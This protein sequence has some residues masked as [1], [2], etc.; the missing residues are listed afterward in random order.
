MSEVTRVAS[1]ERT[2]GGYRVWIKDEPSLVAEGSDFEAADKALW[3]V[4][5][6]ASGD[7]ENL[8][9]YSPPPPPDAGT[10]SGVPH[11]WELA[12]EPRAFIS[13]ADALFEGG[14]CVRCLMPR[15]PRSGVTLGL[16][17][18]LDGIDVTRAEMPRRRL[19]AGPSLSVY[20]NQFLA[21]LSPA[22]RESFTWR[23]VDVPRAGE[24]EFYEM[25]PGV[26]ASY[27]IRKGRAAS[28]RICEECGWKW[29]L[30]RYVPGLPFLSISVKDL[31]APPGGMFA[32]GD[33]A[34]PHLAAGEERWAELV[35]QVGMRGIKGSIVALIPES[36]VERH[37]EYQLRTPE[38]PM[39]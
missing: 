23:P 14:L 5:G 13:N 4:I 37:P 30:P 19:G 11:V 25:I 39:K 29:S 28:F 27:V 31:T 10:P 3:H 12:V 17:A 33:R 15:G 9:D 38:P 18:G 35:G 32:T 24:Q 20:S 7:A 6:M 8:R 36:D 26:T 16:Q 21:L 2:S 1:W 22:E 34:K